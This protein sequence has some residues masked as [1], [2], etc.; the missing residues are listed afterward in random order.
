MRANPKAPTA[1]SAA[2]VTETALSF[3]DPCLVTEL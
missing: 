2:V 1:I 3:G